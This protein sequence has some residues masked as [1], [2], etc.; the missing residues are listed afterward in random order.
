MILYHFVLSSLT[1]EKQRIQ[2]VWPD[3]RVAE[4]VPSGA[5]ESPHRPGSHWNS[6]VTFQVLEFRVPVSPSGQEGAL[7]P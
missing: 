4:K 7:W 5:A 6:D 2:K 1:I 3:G